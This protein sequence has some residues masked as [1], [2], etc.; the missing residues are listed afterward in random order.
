MIKSDFYCLYLKEKN[1]QLWSIKNGL[2]G[3]FYQK[4]TLQINYNRSIF[5]FTDKDNAASLY[6][7]FFFVFFEMRKK[8]LIWNMFS[9]YL[10]K[11]CMYLITLRNS[12]LKNAVSEKWN[13]D[14]YFLVFADWFWWWEGSGGGK[15]QRTN[16]EGKGQTF[17]FWKIW[18]LKIE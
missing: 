3:Y 4:K 18:G 1:N 11:S 7:F 12:A 6:W 13:F 8:L 10:N 5:T 17:A 15:R 2:Y 16:G 14:L 9:I